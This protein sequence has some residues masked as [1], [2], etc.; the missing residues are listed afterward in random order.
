MSGDDTKSN[1]SPADLEKKLGNE[2]F[3]KKEYEL[4]IKHYDKAIELDGNNATYYMFVASLTSKP[5]FVGPG[6][7]GLVPATFYRQLHWNVLSIC[8]SSLTD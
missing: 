4:A 2:A 3:A 6:L 8:F 7:S 1:E 5:S